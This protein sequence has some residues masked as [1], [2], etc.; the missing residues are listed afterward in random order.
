MLQK[1][2]KL[3][4]KRLVDLG[5]AALPPTTIT[6]SSTPNS[7]ANI[8]HIVLHPSDAD[9]ASAAA[10]SGGGGG[11]SCGGGASRSATKQSGPAA[12]QQVVL[13]VQQRCRQ[14]RHQQK[15][16]RQ[17]LQQQHDIKLVSDAWLDAVLSTGQYI[18]EEQYSLSHL[19]PDQQTGGG[20]SS[21]S[22][23]SDGAVSSQQRNTQQQQH[24]GPAVAAAAGGQG[25]RLRA[26]G[27]RFLPDL[28]PSPDAPM[29][30]WVTCHGL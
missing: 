19:L 22:D 6:A 21:V 12:V 27:P 14:Q 20:S 18:P 4:T 16:S 2:L 26:V 7:L 24:Q 28:D 5:A 1:R 17:Q 23:D 30:R 29:G 13:L 8:T 10:G 25:S 15:A 9:V 3:V 11:S